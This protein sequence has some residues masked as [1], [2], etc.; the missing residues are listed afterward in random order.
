MKSFDLISDTHIDFWVPIK[1]NP[2]KQEIR[3]QNYVDEL[4]PENPSNVLVL[5]GDIGHYNR[6][7][8]DFLKKMKKVYQYILIVFGNHDYYMVSNSI[9]KK[10]KNRSYNR[11]NDFIEQCQDIEGVHILDGT[12][13]TIDGI[14]FG[15]AAGWYDLS[16]GPNQLG[17]TPEETLWSWRENSN[18]A[19]LIKNLFHEPYDMYEK[20]RDKIDSVIDEVDIMITHVPPEFSHMSKEEKESIHSSY[21]TFEGEDL[22]KKMKD[23]IWCFGHTHK[24]LDKKVYDCRMVSNALGYPERNKKIEPIQNIKVD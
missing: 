12:M 6:Q 21:Y 16:Y 5:A 15:G 9:R 19:V 18:D 1:H 20:E 8:I 2:V 17:L 24:Q 10:H 11:A 13:I 3:M 7:N 4:I 14:T 23:K 22:I